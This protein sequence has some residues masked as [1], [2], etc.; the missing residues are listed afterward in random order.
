MSTFGEDLIQ[1]L[2]EAVAPAKGNDPAILHSPIA[3]H[4]SEASKSHSDANAS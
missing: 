1:S 4:D 3:S 2:E